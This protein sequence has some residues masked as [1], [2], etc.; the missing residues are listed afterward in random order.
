MLYL[1]ATR[2]NNK[3]WNENRRWHKNKNED[4]TYYGFPRVITNKIPI[5][6]IIF[7]FEMNNDTNEIIGISLIR[8]RRLIGIKCIIYDDNN[9]NRFIYKTKYRI[10]RELLKEKNLDFI[11]KFDLLLFKGKSH[12]KRGQG[13]T[14]IPPK[15]LN[16]TN[17]NNESVLKNIFVEHFNSK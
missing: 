4:E 7:I 9:Y 14:I 11:K 6:A 13:V 12:L 8:N 3:T 2:F 1:V 17:Y 5:N 15:L 16:T 10:D